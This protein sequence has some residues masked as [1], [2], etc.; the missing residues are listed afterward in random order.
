MPVPGPQ[1]L[2]LEL[3]WP[4]WPSSSSP[5]LCSPSSSRSCA[6]R[7]GCERRERRRARG[8]RVPDRLPRPRRPLPG[9]VL[10]HELHH[11]RPAP[12]R[13][14][15]RRP[16]GRAPTAGRLHGPRLLQRATP[17]RREAGL[18]RHRRRPRRGPAL[19]GLPAQPAGL[20]VRVDPGPVRLPAGPGLPPPV[21]GHERRRARPGVEHR[22]LVRHQHELAVLLGRVDH[23]LPRPDGR[24]GRAELR[25]G[26]RRH[27]GRDRPRAW[28]RTVAH[29]PARQLLGR[30]PPRHHADPA[31][32]LVRVRPRP[33]RRRAG[34]ELRPDRRPDHA[35]GRDAEPHRRAGRLP[36]GHQGARHQRGWLLQ[37]QLVPPVRERPGVDQPA[38][39]LPAAG[40]PVQP[41]AHLRPDGREHPP[42]LRDRRRDGHAVPRLAEPD[43]RRRGRPPRHRAAGGRRLERGQGGALRRRPVRLLRRRHHDDVHRG[44]RLVPLQLH[45]PRRRAGD[46]RHDARRGQPRRH[47]VRAVRDARPRHPQRLH[48][49]PHGRPDAGVPRQEARRPRDQVR[50]PLPPRRARSWSWSAPGSP[51]PSP[52]RATRCSTRGRTA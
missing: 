27:R 46:V 16:R 43:D 14:R 10:T 3:R 12:G 30:P 9:T 6:E 15:H 23:G 5:W 31:A 50:L 36:G 34:P 42:G 38:R 25:L 17:P 29:R 1:P 19:D 7:T 44:R 52:G 47:R 40:H 51:W 11:C 2:P 18:P 35:V 32:A 26:R 28:A 24:P 48:R 4:T 13:P 37:R 41:A 8:G 39:D 20:L 49:R 33:R 21:A 45:R 22:G